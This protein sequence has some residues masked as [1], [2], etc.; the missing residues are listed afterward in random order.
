[1]LKDTRY[2]EMLVHHSLML[3]LYCVYINVTISFYTVG[4]RGSLLLGGMYR[5][6]KHMSEG[7]ELVRK[8]YITAFFFGG[9]GSY[10]V[11]MISMYSQLTAVQLF[12]L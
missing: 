8:G 10:Q 2:I 7:A 4:L 6:C 5:V 3:Q 9:G 1:M 12:Y 11:V